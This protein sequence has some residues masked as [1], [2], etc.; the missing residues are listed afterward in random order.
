MFADDTTLI[1]PEKTQIEINI[2]IKT[3]MQ[4]YSRGA[5]FNK[6]QH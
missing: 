2:R 6:T 1:I 3:I 4:V 5:Q